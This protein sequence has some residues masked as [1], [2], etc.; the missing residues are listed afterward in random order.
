MP[1]EHEYLTKEKYQE[2]QAELEAL[3]H[4]KRKEVAKN[5]EY[6]KSLG[7]L[8][9]NAEYHAAREAQAILEDR[10]KKLEMLLKHAEVVDRHDGDSVSVGAE[11]TIKR[12]DTGDEYTYVIV[13]SEEA[14][15]GSGK[16]S[17]KSPLGSAILGK[18]KKEEF[19]VDTPGGEVTYK[20]VSIK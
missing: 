19:S 5:L 7:D 3:K 10:I 16:I 14:D 2:F 9:E 12:V 18:K 11:V 6:A 13:G 8:S 20:I 1:E 4:D 15:M 17:N